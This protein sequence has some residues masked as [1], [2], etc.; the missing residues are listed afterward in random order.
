MGGQNGESRE[1]KGSTSRLSHVTVQTLPFD[2]VQDGERE[3]E[4]ELVSPSIL[5]PSFPPLPLHQR[6][7]SK[8]FTRPAQPPA[9]GC[10]A[11]MAA[12]PT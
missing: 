6:G 10:A 3:T 2:R 5:S 7:T 11:P 8:T 4:E 12:L 1:K 9:Q